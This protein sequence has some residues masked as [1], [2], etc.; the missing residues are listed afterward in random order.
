MNNVHALLKNCKFTELLS[1][2]YHPFSLA[3]WD[4]YF[5]YSVEEIYLKLEETMFLVYVSHDMADPIAFQRL[6]FYRTFN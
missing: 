3:L 1:I 2:E 5:Y 6:I 4:S